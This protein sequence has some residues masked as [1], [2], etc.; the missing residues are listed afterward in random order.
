MSLRP[1]GC[2]GDAHDQATIA[3]VASFSD[4]GTTYVVGPHQAGFGSKSTPVAACLQTPTLILLKEDAITL[5]SCT[6]YHHSWL[7]VLLNLPARSC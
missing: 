4:G 3:S 7:I 1:P 6:I 2:S 5:L